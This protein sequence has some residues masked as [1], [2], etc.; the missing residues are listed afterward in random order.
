MGGGLGEV[1]K[2]AGQ[3]MN[4]LDDGLLGFGAEVTV[5]G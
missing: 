2:G 4:V 1:L 3:G 5:G